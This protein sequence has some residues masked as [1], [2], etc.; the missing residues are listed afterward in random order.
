M[1]TVVFSILSLFI[2]S[3]ALCG[4]GGGGVV[5]PS[6]NFMFSNEI[7]GS[8]LFTDS[9][10]N[11]EQVKIESYESGFVTFKHK[12]QGSLKVKTYSL[13]VSDLSIKYLRA[14]EKSASSETFEMVVK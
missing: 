9:D 1:K 3:Q 5:R 11:N 13:N 12:P 10:I 4:T 14:L 7:S 2:G 8:T 6:Q